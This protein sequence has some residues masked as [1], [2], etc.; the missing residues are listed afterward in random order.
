[1][2]S[3]IEALPAVVDAVGGKAPVLMDGSVRLGSDVFKALA[4]GA[5]AVLL[6]RPTIWGLAAYGA[7]GVQDVIELIQSEFA[8][9]MAM[10]GKLNLAALDRNA[11]KVHRR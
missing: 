10:C 7:E 1:V 3:P 9:D 11:V 5:N 6:G 8:R 4:L 2:A